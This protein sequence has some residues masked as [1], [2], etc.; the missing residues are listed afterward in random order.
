MKPWI[1][2]YTGRHLNPLDLQPEDI[3][4]EDVAHQ[5]ACQTRWCGATKEPIFTAQH[6][7]FVARYVRDQTPMVQLQALLHE[8]PEAYLGDVS[9]WVKESSTMKAYRAAENKAWQATCQKFKMQLEL[10]PAVEEA[11]RVMAA[12]EAYHSMHPDCETLKVEGYEITPERLARAGQF[13]FWSWHR[14]EME[15]MRYFIRVSHAAN[16]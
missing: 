13:E 12:V 4:I 15:F 14:A 5:L 3:V 6:C 16:L 11:D 8:V 7:V 2:T 9:K 1:T 10:Y